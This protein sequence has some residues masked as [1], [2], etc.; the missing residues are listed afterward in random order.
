MTF[1]FRISDE[2]FK[3]TR[4]VYRYIDFLGDIGGLLGFF[5]AIFMLVA[6][7]FAYKGVYHFLTP[8]LFKVAKKE[9]KSKK[10]KYVPQSARSTK[11]LNGME[12]I[13]FLKNLVETKASEALEAVGDIRK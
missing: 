10:F 13:N 7:I 1:K 5:N 9:E 8:E 2:L 4:S 12:T 11:N 3:T 6:Q